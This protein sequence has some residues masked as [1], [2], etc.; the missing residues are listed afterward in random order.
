MPRS[1]SCALERRLPTPTHRPWP[2][3]PVPIPGREIEVAVERGGG[4]RR[5][6]EGPAERQSYSAP[7]RTGGSW[8]RAR[9]ARPGEA[10]PRGSA[11]RSRHVGLR[12]SGGLTVPPAPPHLPPPQLS[13][14]GPGWSRLLSLLP[15]PG[16][17]RAPRPGCA[18][19]MRLNGPG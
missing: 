7:R 4:E 18:C 15:G 8:E 14:P 11:E 5:L 9:P 6:K 19:A 10:P 12:E 13:S 3:G 1:T 17:K 2:G 16:R